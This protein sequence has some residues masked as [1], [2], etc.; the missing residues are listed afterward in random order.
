[1]PQDRVEKMAIGQRS[2]GTAAAKSLDKRAVAL[3]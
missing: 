2:A 1:M 3:L